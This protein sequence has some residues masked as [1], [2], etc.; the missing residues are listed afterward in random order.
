MLGEHLWITRFKIHFCS[1]AC[2][3]DSALVL[4]FHYFDIITLMLSFVLCTLFQ[5]FVQDKEKLLVKRMT[6]HAP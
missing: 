2:N 1:L 5:L 3:T 6:T 4:V